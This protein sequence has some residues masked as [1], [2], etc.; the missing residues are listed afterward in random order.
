MTSTRTTLRRIVTLLWPYKAAT[1]GVLILAL[2]AAGLEAA[3]PLLLV[4]I[5]DQ[6]GVADALRPLL[7][8][9]AGLVMLE[10]TYA[11][12]SGWL[13]VA[14]ENLTLQLDRSMREQLYGKLFELP[15]GYYRHHPVGGVMSRVGQSLERFLEAFAEIAFEQLPTLL[16]FGVALVAM[17]K[18][19]WRLAVLVISFTPL[20][21]LT[22][23]WAAREQARRERRLLD[24]EASV[25]G[26]LYET[27]QGLLTVKGFGREHA[28]RR[29][30]LQGVSIVHAI[31]RRG[32]RR[33][34]VTEGLSDLPYTLARLVTIGIGAVLVIRGEI[35]IGVI[36]GFLG[37]IE[38][39]FGPVQGLAE[40]YQT[41]RRASVSLDAISEIMDAEDPV[42]DAPNAVHLDVGPATVQFDHVSFGYGP[43]GRVLEDISLTLHPGETVALLGPNGSG[44]TTLGLLLL[45]LYPVD[46]GRITVDGIDLRE[47]TA[48]SLRKHIAAV[49]Q[50]LHLFDGTIGENIAFGRP[51]ATQREI[52]AVARA[53]GASTFIERLPKRFE[54]RVEVGHGL[55]RGQRQRLA[56]ARAL[57]KDAP[58]LFLD[59]PTSALDADGANHLVDTLESLTAGRTT[60]LVTHRL[61]FAL[62]ADRIGLLD[63][64]RLV[65][66][67]THDELLQTCER[68]VA[69]VEAA[70]RLEGRSGARWRRRDTGG[71]RTRV[72]GIA[73]FGTPRS[74]RAPPADEQSRLASRAVHRSFLL[75]PNVSN[76][77][78]GNGV[79]I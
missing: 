42:A 5:I 25:A 26:R 24:Q 12:L 68:Y 7:L 9:V 51:D 6:L 63:G 77:M 58:I 30:V 79:F 15:L 17:V 59:E 35:T 74:T 19:D 31:G 62:K 23:A 65:A 61:S 44:K 3:E 69:L 20:P 55:S 16:Y 72:S 60:L 43:E 50:H 56:V 54:T 73:P 8:A 78:I 46:E 33:D 22:A 49:F 4:I 45:R 71:S 11:G 34:A 13:A 52:E 32:A 21:P 28:K 76:E 47:C 2:V 27:L 75:S 64:G 10:L 14:S 67:G 39:L 38:G 48:A 18:L 57:L 40:V 70:E 41:L 66:V 53:A 1:G 36:V 29:K 37:Y